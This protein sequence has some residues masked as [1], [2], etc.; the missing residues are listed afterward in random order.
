[1]N[2]VINSLQ[3]KQQVMELL[4]QSAPSS[5]DLTQLL[6]ELKRAIVEEVLIHTDGNQTRAAAI[7][8]MNRETLRRLYLQKN[9]VR[10][11]T[12]FL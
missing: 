6:P 5:P 11:I 10:P 12:A 7:L 8:G 1:M 9:L 2:K 3:F 4:Y